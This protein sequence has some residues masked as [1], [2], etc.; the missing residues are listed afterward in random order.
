VEIAR[1]TPSLPQRGRQPKRASPLDPMSREISYAAEVAIRYQS[2]FLV[3]LTSMIF[4]EQLF[5]Q[6]I[7]KG[8]VLV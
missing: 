1:V 6:F 2:P 5:E 8:K 3:F 7:N 4:T